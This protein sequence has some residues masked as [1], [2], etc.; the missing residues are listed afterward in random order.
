[1]VKSAYMLR[2]ARPLVLL[3]YIRGIWSRG[4]NYE[5]LPRNSKYG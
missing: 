5:N 3:D 2:F 1:M 4:F